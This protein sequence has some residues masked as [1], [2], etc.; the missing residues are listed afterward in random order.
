MEGALIAT[1][2]NASLQAL[3][4]G[5][6]LAVQAWEQIHGYLAR[7]LGPDHAAL[8][9]EPNPD[10]ARGVTDWYAE[11]QGDAVPI[12][13]L[14]APEKDAARARFAELYQA[15]QTDIAAL[16]QSRSEGD[17]FL[18]E[19]LA[20]ALVTPAPDSL[21]V[22]DG[23]PVLV[24]WGHAPIGASAAPEMLI[25]HLPGQATPPSRARKMVILGPP[26]AVRRTPW[27]WIVAGL[28]LL[29]L[30]LALLLLLIDPFGWRKAPP[31]MCVVDPRGFAALDEL[32][33][34][35]AR[36]TQLRAQLARLALELGDRR[37][38]CPPVARPAPARGSQ[39]I[40]PVS[41]SPNTNADINRATQQGGKQGRIQIVL[42]W[43][44]VADLD[45]AVKCPTGEEIMFRNRRA[46]GGELDVDQNV[47]TPVPNP[48]ENIVFAEQPPAGT[49]QV[50][51]VNNGPRLGGRSSPFR[52]T[53]RQ[54]GVPDKVFTGEIPPT[55]VHAV[56]VFRVPAQ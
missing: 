8:F 39:A 45:L 32:R 14:P 47:G 1:T 4:T 11:G 29:A 56:G 48:V 41:P 15:I 19:L 51:V 17:R 42:A 54:E 37:A 2:Q 7:R 21:R 38:S 55:Q 5:G 18:A 16:R 9:A 10:P 35:E 43:D 40:P 22:I 25:G 3:G 31:P 30:L 27:G 44:D 50:F 53:L 33:Q 13:T 23:R 20:L 46:C 28:G 6:Q 49:Y 26:P 36:E 24:A 12:D 34:E 52:V